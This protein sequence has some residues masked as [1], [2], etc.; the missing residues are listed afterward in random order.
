MRQL[1]KKEKEGGGQC[2]GHSEMCIHV[3]VHHHQFIFITC[4]P[5]FLFSLS[6]FFLSV[7]FFLLGDAREERENHCTGSAGSP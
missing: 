6:F 7:H 4:F 3:F 1:S 2:V 5:F